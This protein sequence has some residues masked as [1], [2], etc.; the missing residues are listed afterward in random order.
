[1]GEWR[2]A[3]SF[4]TS[5]LDGS[6][7]SASGPGGFTLGT[8][9]LG[10]WMGPRMSVSYGEEKNLALDGIHINRYQ[11]FNTHATPSYPE[12]IQSIL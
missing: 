4:L 11:R 7:W 3:L 5:A 8:H 9:W 1:M 6:E 10:G 2:I 12:S